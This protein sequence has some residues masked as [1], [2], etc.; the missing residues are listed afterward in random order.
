MKMLVSLRT[1]ATA[2]AAAT[3]RDFQSKVMGEERS[4]ID[5]AGYA[6]TPSP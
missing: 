3:P 1:A 2:S 6:L 5:L 4:A